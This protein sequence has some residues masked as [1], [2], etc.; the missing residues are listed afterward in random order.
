MTFP[1][2]LTSVTP[3]SKYLAFS[4]FVILP[5]L[6]FFW[7]ANYTQIKNPNPILEEQP[8]TSNKKTLPVLDV[9][10]NQYI[11]EKWQIYK[12]TAV[13]FT[14]KYPGNLKK[15]VKP[16]GTL[17][18]N[19]SLLPTDTAAIGITDGFSFGFSPF[20]GTLDEFIEIRKKVQRG[21]GSSYPD[22]PVSEIGIIKFNGI[23]GRWYALG[24]DNYLH[25][26]TEVSFV[27][28]GYAFILRIDSN[29]GGGDSNLNTYQIEQLLSTFRYL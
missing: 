13:G 28:K 16:S 8:Q 10:N 11:T 4:L 21:A 5:V 12:N 2:E 24:L 23:T 29:S 17:V 14:F 26:D 25:P 22:E 1:K 19:E 18:P 15:M 7:G 27:H 3:L 9:E 20:N 6:T